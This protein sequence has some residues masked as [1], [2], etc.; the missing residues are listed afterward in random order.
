MSLL[1][2]I[3]DIAIKL[4]ASDIHLCVKANPSVRINGKISKIET[5]PTITKEN[6]DEFLK[7]ICSEDRLKEL[8]EKKQIDLSYSIP[9]KGR[10]RI[11][12]FSQRNNI[13][14]AIRIINSEI[15]K[16]SDLGLPPILKSLIKNKNGLI[17]VTGPTGSGKTTTL[18]SM[19]N[20]INETEQCH[21][22]TIEDPIEF[23]H[24]NKKSIINQ[25]EIGTD[26]NNFSDALKV[27]LRQDPDVISI[28]EMRDLET[29][30]I[31]LTASETGHLVFAT[32][33]TTNAPS[34]IDRIID[35]FS[36]TQQQQIKI[37]LSDV[38]RGIISQRLVP[39]VENKRVL[40][41]EILI[42]N[43]AIKNLIREGKTHQIR[44][45]MQTSSSSGMIKMDTYLTELYKKDII[46]QSTLNDYLQL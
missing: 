26:V 19:I 32:L 28:G 29:I 44:N 2:K 23:L 41:L 46:S 7:E 33:H 36:A 45:T 15:P 35:V 43:Q 13:S 6:I 4:N 10:F 1:L 16:M 39:T 31:A 5:L 12:I 14:I 25:R 34:T 17:L 9:D 24:K 3:I 11:N 27:A 18:T 37:Q 38:L 21:I 42:N 8:K 20:E 40:A 30:Q 22:L